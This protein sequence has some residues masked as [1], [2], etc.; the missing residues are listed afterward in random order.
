MAANVPSSFDGMSKDEDEMDLLQKMILKVKQ[1]PLVPLGCLATTGAIIMATRSVRQ[2][3]RLKTQMY[4]RMRIGLQL[5]TLIALVVGGYYYQTES[6]E[7]KISKEEK[8]RAKA[9]LREK[10]WIEELERRDEETK[11]RQRRLESSRRELNQVAQESF[12]K[13][14]EREETPSK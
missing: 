14:R 10:M 3:D 9:K 5:A 6:I 13:E 11:E 1:Q 2:G 4:F 12:A 7:K 8:L